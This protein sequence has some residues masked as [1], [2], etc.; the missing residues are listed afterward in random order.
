MFPMNLSNTDL[1]EKSLSRISLN[2]NED[3]EFAWIN[4]VPDTLQYALNM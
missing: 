1:I 3:D 4:R 2:N